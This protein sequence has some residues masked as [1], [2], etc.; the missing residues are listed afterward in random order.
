MISISFSSGLGGRRSVHMIVSEMSEGFVRACAVTFCRCDVHQSHIHT[1]TH[2]YTCM[3]VCI[4][5]YIYTHTHMHHIHVHRTHS[6]YTFCTSYNEA[7]LGS[8]H[9]F[10]F[11]ENSFTFAFVYITDIHTHTYPCT[12]D[13]RAYEPSCMQRHF[14]LTAF[15][16]TVFVCVCV[17][18][19]M[20]LCFF[21]SHFA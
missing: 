13:T 14:P 4:Y 5:I 12:L 10:V 17:C 16:A 19:C 20:Y 7:K 9:S 15:P 8:E 2:A 18:V 6:K 21:K 1:C 3:Y 11:Y